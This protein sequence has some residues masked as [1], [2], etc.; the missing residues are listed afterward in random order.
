MLKIIMTDLIVNTSKFLT[1]KHGKKFWLCICR[2]LD[3]YYQ[4]DQ[5][6]INLVRQMNCLIRHNN[7]KSSLAARIFYVDKLFTFFLF[8]NK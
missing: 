7:N 4:L 6:L 5:L 3:Q 8:K 1:C 2:S